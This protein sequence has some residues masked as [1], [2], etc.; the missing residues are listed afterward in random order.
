M[1][2][3][4]AYLRDL[5][6]LGKLA[7]AE[8]P[9]DYR[10]LQVT[11]AAGQQL[12]DLGALLGQHSLPSASG[13]Y[14]QMHAPLTPPECEDPIIHWCD[15]AIYNGPAYEPGPCDC[16]GLKSSS[17]ALTPQQRYR[18]CEI[19]HETADPALRA[20]AIALLVQP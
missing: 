3:N 9:Q 19:A 14:T 6:L 8:M 7:G 5:E 12:G 2:K 10:N 18:L 1:T 16:G 15:C 11:T 4:H 17:G 13:A 20:A